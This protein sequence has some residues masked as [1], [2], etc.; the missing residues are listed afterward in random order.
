MIRATDKAENVSENR[1]SFTVDRIPAPT[2]EE[3]TGRIEEV[4]EIF[5]SGRSLPNLQV[6]LAFE[7][8]GH[9]FQEEIVADDT[10]HWEFRAQNFLAV[11]GYTVKA[12]AVSSDGIDGLPSEIKKLNVYKEGELYRIGPWA[13]PYMTLA[14]ILAIV[15]GVILL[16]ILIVF[17]MRWIA[18]ARRRKRR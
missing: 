2:F 9:V 17:P 16:L 3:F 6:I 4:D 8:E 18:I 14:A 11:G 15:I 7:K 10:G 12:F 5:I 1:V 13:I